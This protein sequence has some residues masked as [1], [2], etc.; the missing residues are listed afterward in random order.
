[1]YFFDAS[2]DGWV[3]RV[4][5]NELRLYET[6]AGVVGTEVQN[7]G[8]A[9]H[10][11]SDVFE[12]EADIDAGTI[13]AFVNNVARGAAFSVD[14]TGTAPGIGIIWDNA[15]A[16]GIATAE[17]TGVPFVPALTLD[18]APSTIAKGETG[19]E[20]VVS[21]PTTVP[22]A[23]NTTVA[24]AGVELTVTGVTGAGPYTITCTAP[25]DIAKQVGSYVW[26]IGIEA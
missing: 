16:R 15:K 5:G 8:N 24:N 10:I 2:G 18:S 1:M 25:L 21:T 20:F 3:A 17:F 4:N 19:L 14:L 13:Q 6:T 7:N 12:L 26:T 9:A 11:A 23:L 22:T